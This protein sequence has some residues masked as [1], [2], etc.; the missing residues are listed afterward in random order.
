MDRKSSHKKKKSHYGHDEDDDDEDDDDDDDELEY[1]DDEDSDGE[2]GDDEEIKYSE[3]FDE[4]DITKK[5]SYAKK[6]ESII[7]STPPAPQTAY[8]K[9]QEKTRQRILEVLIHAY[10]SGTYTFSF[11]TLL[12]PYTK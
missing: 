2:A 5:T 1:L 3:F 11:L 4:P 10:F 7:K 6:N 9:M 8:E 12:F